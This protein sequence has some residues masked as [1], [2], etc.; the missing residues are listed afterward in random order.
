[1]PEQ[2][3]HQQ[4]LLQLVKGTWRAWAKR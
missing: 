1:M 2:L 3:K 4:I